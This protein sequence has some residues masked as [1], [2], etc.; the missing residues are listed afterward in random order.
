MLTL[1]YAKYFK[2][3]ALWV[4]FNFKK[5]YS[6]SRKILFIIM[7]LKEIGE[8]RKIKK[9]V[10]TISF[11]YN[12]E[13]D[14]YLLYLKSNYLW[15]NKIKLHKEGNCLWCYTLKFFKPFAV[16]QT[17]VGYTISSYIWTG[18]VCSA[19]RGV[20]YQGAIFE[21]IERA[22]F[23]CGD[24]IRTKRLMTTD[25]QWITHAQLTSVG[26]NFATVWKVDPSILR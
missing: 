10:S 7:S 18:N 1:K 25:D 19:E 12:I 15:C 2:F 9:S 11:E 4:F 8:S 14:F 5:V 20:T 22:I 23:V 6:D 26:R 3:R 13:Y 16:R 21:F 17:P 24:K